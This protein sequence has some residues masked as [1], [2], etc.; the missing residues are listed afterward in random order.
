MPL[1]AKYPLLR[2]MLGRPPLRHP[3][4]KFLKRRMP[5]HEFRVV[6]DVGANEGDKAAE[7]LQ[8]F[9]NARIWAFEPVSATCA[10]LRARFAPEPRVEVRQEALG[11]SQT[12]ARIL[13]SGISVSNR[14]VT[15]EEPG[16][17]Y[18]R[19]AVA[20]GDAFLAGA[21]I[22]EID[23]IKIDTEGHDLEVLIGFTEALQRKAIRFIQVE[24]GMNSTN[25][26]HVPIHDFMQFLEPLGYHI[27]RIVD[28]VLE[29]DNRAILRRADLIF[30]R[31]RTPAG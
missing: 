6:V 31:G 27:Y 22:T 1:L 17:R 16:S 14:I 11:S 2:R 12:T 25:K 30:W 4:F 23:F 15:R 28:Q 26:L 3:L 20:T 9:P 29:Y 21:G 5:L 19:V 8:H 10:K 7:Y 13:V 18:E 24:A